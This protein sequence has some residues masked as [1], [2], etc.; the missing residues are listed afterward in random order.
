MS[1]LGQI[2][3]PLNLISETPDKWVVVKIPTFPAMDGG[4]GEPLY[5]VF[6]TWAGGYDDGDRWK[7]NS[8]IVKV[9]QDEEYFYF[10]GY[11]GSCYK[12]HKKG[13]GFMTS[14]GAGTLDGIIKQASEA[15]VDVEIMPETKNWMGLVADRK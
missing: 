3:I 13:Y 15:G 10:F 8:G 9:E 1:K 5:K 6:A 11:S 2:K 4:N 14:Y 7:L 12:C